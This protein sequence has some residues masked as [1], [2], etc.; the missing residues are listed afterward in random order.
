MNFKREMLSLPFDEQD[1]INDA[2]YMHYSRNKKRIVVREN[3]LCNQHY[4]D[5]GE[6]NHLQVL[7]PGQLLKV[8]LQSLHWTAGKRPS[9]SKKMQET[10]Q[11]CY[12]PSIALFVKIWVWECEI[13]IQESR[14]NNTRISPNLYHIPKRNLRPEDLMQID[15]LPELRPS[16]YYEN[17]ITAID[18]S[19]T[20]GKL[21]SSS[22]QPTAVNTA[23]VIRDSITRHAYLSRLFIIDKRSVFVSQVLHEVAIILGIV[24]KHAKTEHAQNIGVLE[25]AHTTIKTSLKF[26]SGEYRN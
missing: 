8:L 11:Y 23:K 5:L 20:D 6:V 9:R 19:L 16:G 22:F 13:C 3:L 18:V 24:L 10:R 21:G 1:L 2:R 25:L 15:V 17:I 14:I 4:A 12:F 7:L 26:A